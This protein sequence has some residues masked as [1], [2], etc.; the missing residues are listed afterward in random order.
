MVLPFLLI[1]LDDSRCLCVL[2]CTGEKA[3]VES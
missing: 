3:G 2:V 1:L